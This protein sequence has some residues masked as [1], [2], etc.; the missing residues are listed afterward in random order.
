M[1]LQNIQNAEHVVSPY[2]IAT[3]TV[4]TAENEK[5]AIVR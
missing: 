5:S 3:A 1:T 4:H 2:F